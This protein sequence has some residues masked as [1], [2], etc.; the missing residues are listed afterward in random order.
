MIVILC[1]PPG[2]G[3]TT[4]ATR[5]RE[6][7]A[8]RGHD[9]SILHSDDFSRRTYERM[10]DRVVGSDDDWIIDGTFYRRE[11]QERFRALD[12]VYVVWVTAA[13]ETCLER[14]LAREEPIS[15]TGVHVVHAEFA[16]PAADLVIDTDVRTVEEAV[17]RLEAAVRSWLDGDGSAAGVDAPDSE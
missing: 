16:D 14:N 17:D 5:L 11:W 4:L 6:R 1:G 8:E 9:V 7:L 13:V 2:M 12:D 10:Y 3:K 15:E